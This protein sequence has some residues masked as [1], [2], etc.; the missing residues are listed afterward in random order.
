[1]LISS[2]QQYYVINCKTVTIQFYLLIIQ[3]TV[4]NRK[5]QDLLQ[6]IKVVYQRVRWDMRLASDN[7]W[8]RRRLKHLSWRLRWIILCTL[9]QRTAVLCE[10]SRA[11]WCHFGLSSWLSTRSSTSTRRTRSTAAWLP[12]N[13]T[14]L[15]DSLQQTADASSFPTVGK[16]TQRPSCTITFWQIDFKS[17]SHLP[18]KFSWFCLIFLHIFRS[19][20][21]PKVK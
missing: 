18:V 13:C 6:T 15:V 8:A 2:T 21:F 9:E 1:V 11:D 4:Y 5:Y 7:S 3:L 16:F 20:Q 17:E 19:R 12:D 14:R 10:I